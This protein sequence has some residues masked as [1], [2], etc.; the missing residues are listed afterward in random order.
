MFDECKL[1][2]RRTTDLGQKAVS[3]SGDVEFDLDDYQKF[4]YHHHIQ[5]SYVS[6]L[7]RA[8]MSIILEQSK[9]LKNKDLVISIILWHT[10]YEATNWWIRKHR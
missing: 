2:Y 7:H 4:K 5:K 10:S 9:I 6:T 8:P 1:Y 3:V